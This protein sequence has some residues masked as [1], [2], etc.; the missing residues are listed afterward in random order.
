MVESANSW[1][2]TISSGTGEN[3]F[4]VLNMIK[5]CED[6][7]TWSSVGMGKGDGGVRSQSLVVES[8]NSSSWR[9]PMPAAG[10]EREEGSRKDGSKN[11]SFFC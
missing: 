2:R 10:R 9:L 8:A 11:L 6:V 3:I 7:L 1:I 4:V 5:G